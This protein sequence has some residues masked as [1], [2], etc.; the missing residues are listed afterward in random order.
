M[1]ES[2][3]WAYIKRGMLGYWHATR[4]ESSA[5]NGVPDVNF[6]MFESGN[7]GWVELKYID[8]WP[9]RLTT[10]VKLPLRPEQKLWINVRG[11]IS[12]N[13]WVIIRIQEHFFL[14]QWQQIN[15]ACEGWTS[16]EWIENSHHTW[17]KRIEFFELVDQLNTK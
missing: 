13:I 5:G 15:D 4:I 1:N 8:E 6:A 17:Y 7:Q 2:G 12:G 3:L 9:K 10:K 11:K 16:C 14:L